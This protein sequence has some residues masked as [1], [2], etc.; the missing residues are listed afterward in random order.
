MKKEDLRILKTK[1]SLYRSLLELMKNKT[2]EEI[3]ISDLCNN[4]N[5][6]RS[7]FYDHYQDKYELL[8]SIFMDRKK[9]LLESFQ[10]INKKNNIYEEM[11]SII[12]N[13][14]EQYLSLY[15]LSTK[16]NGYSMA[17]D[18]MMDA[19]ITYLPE[20]DY[21]FNIFYTSGLLNTLFQYIET[22]K[23][24]NKDEISKILNTI[25]NNTKK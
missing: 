13:H 21:Y 16:I 19:M 23:E 18:M 17:K 25:I 6:N 14:I 5:I 3:K 22:S 10:E 1:A 9:E 12:L 8:N 20:E 15:I 24:F 2:F 7:T 4:S 11:I